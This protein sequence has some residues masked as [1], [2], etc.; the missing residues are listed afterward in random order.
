MV[1]ILARL[2][3]QRDAPVA[4]SEL[5]SSKNI[6]KVRKDTKRKDKNAKRQKRDEEIEKQRAENPVKEESSSEEEDQ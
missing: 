2:E 1:E 3:E 5:Y 6:G 4:S